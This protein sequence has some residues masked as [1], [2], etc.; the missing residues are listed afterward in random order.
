MAPQDNQ[1]KNERV[2]L[3]MVPSEAPAKS[4]NMISF[5][6]TAQ[7]PGVAEPPNKTISL[8]VAAQNPVVAESGN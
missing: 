4:N 2:T 5:D 8:D 1:E 3:D 6:M 7:E